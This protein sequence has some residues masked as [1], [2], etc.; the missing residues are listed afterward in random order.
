M[1]SLRHG[2]RLSPSADLSFRAGA[3]RRIFLVLSAVPRC[4]NTPRDTYTTIWATKFACNCAFASA[5]SDACAGQEC[6]KDTSLHALTPPPLMRER[7]RVLRFS[8]PQAPVYVMLP[9]SDLASKNVYQT[10]PTSTYM[11]VLGVV[12]RFACTTPPLLVQI[13][14]EV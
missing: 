8:A 7:N 10:E 5:P 9:P 6:A 1:R 13:L 2:C 11:A 3:R 14:P 12:V 4:F